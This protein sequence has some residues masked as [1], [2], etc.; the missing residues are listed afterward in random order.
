[1]PLT[2]YAGNIVH[3]STLINAWHRVWR[4]DKQMVSNIVI[5]AKILSAKSVS[6]LEEAAIKEMLNTDKN[7]PLRSCG[8]C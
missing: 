6:K 2:A 8:E 4:S 5:Y 3:K 7:V 1:V